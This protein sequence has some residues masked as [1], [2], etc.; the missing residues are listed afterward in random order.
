MGQT[1]PLRALTAE[2][3]QQLQAG[4]RS[5]RAFTLRR[6]QIL[7]A[8]AQGLRP[9]QFAALIGC[10]WATVRNVLSDFHERGITCVH[11]ERPREGAL[12]RGRPRLEEKQPG[13]TAALERLL[14]DDIAG[15]PMTETRGVRVTL[16]RLSEQLKEQGYP[17]VEKTVRRLL[18]QMG[19]S[20]KANRK[21]QVRSR[22]PE[23]MSSSASSPP[24]SKPSP[25]WG[26]P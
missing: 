12:R 15:D 10:T 17:A 11:R 19:F 3:I 1:P 26:C 4:L 6:R 20:M 24:Q 9:S 18:K 14:I 22:R 8:H 23:R 16:T 5:P 7:L 25:R 13:I 21:R 2:E